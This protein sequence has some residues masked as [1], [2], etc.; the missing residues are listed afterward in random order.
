MPSLQVSS[1]VKID[2]QEVLKG[3]AKS[4][5][6]DLERFMEQLS[7]LI[8]RKKV[9]SLSKKET[10]LIKKINRGL[11]EKIQSRYSKLLP[12]SVNHS[13]TE[14]EYQELSDILPMME[15]LGVERLK[16]M[17]ELATLWETSVDEVMKRLGIKPPPAI[18]AE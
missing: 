16:H 10:E 1:N 17:I 6:S 13:L 12:K 2:F 11:P 14:T 8:A 15:N 5:V 7:I 18:Y 3:F 9:P 4:E